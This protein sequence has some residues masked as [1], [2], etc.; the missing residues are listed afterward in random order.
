M[1]T[2][3]VADDPK[4]SFII[5]GKQKRS[6]S[7]CFPDN[8]RTIRD[9]STPSQFAFPSNGYA[10]ISDTGGFPRWSSTQRDSPR[11]VYDSLGNKSATLQQQSDHPHEHNTSTFR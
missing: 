11:F 3:V 1:E 6:N 7:L 10:S 9:Y 8:N 4:P 5:Y 2:T